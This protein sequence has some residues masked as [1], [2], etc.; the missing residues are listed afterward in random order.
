MIFLVRP[1]CIVVA[2][3]TQV[4]FVPGGSYNDYD[5]LEGTRKQMK[6]I[7]WNFTK[8]HECIL[9]DYL[10]VV[11][12]FDFREFVFE[13]PRQ[14]FNKEIIKIR[15]RQHEHTSQCDG[16]AWLT[17]ERGAVN[18]WFPFIDGVTTSR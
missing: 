17:R 16:P 13:Y 7:I 4:Y 10:G 11:P 8:A 2:Q 3:I 5:L 15:A 9:E 14:D 18:S 1:T 6:K 12:M